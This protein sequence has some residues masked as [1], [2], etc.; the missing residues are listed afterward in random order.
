MK[1]AARIDS[2][3]TEIVEG[4]RK[5]GYSVA[6]T[7]AVGNGFVDIIVGRPGSNILMEIKDPS[8]KPSKRRLTS[9]QVK[10]HT[11]WKGPIAV[12]E[13]LEEALAV[14]QGHYNKAKLKQL[15]G[16]A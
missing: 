13:T 15:Q 16:E 9:D 7:S 11:E 4:L 12:I 2:N 14:M 1:R 6:I 5:C 10:F 3:Q 8:Q